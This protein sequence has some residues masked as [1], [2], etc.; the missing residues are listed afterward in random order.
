MTGNEPPHTS[1]S[2]QT[3]SAF[4]PSTLYIAFAFPNPLPPP[5]RVARLAGAAASPGG[6]RGGGGGGED[7][8]PSLPRG[9]QPGPGTAARLRPPPRKVPEEEK[10][11]EEGGESAAR[12]GAG[13]GG[14]EGKGR[15]GYGAFLAGAA[16]STAARF[17]CGE[18]LA[19]G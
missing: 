4:I 3:L 8:L 13:R 16:A 17:V 6:G 9:A 2:F 1:P 15:A 14:G 11:E 10:E 18:S 7:R 12:G 19:A 5:G